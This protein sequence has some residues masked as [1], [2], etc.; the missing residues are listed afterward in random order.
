M[1]YNDAGVT[2]VTVILDKPADWESWFQLRREKAVV[3]A[4]WKYHDISKPQS[5]LP[6]LEEPV[7]PLPSD[8][9]AGTTAIAQ[10]D[11]GQQ[12]MYSDLLHD[13]RYE[14]AEYAKKKQKEGELLLDISRTIAARHL[15]LINNCYT[16]QRAYRQVSISAGRPSESRS[17]AVAR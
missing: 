13:W 6:K 16:N 17:R 4:I 2:R 7:K 15:Y 12:A 1:S 10:L 3:D 11:A 5:E 9:R 8:V 14:R